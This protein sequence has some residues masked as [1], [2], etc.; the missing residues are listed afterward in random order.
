MTEKNKRE[1]KLSHGEKIFPAF[2]IEADGRGS[3]LSVLISGIIGVKEFSSEEV[4][5]ITRRESIKLTGKGL[6]ISVFEAKTVEISGDIET[7]SFVSKSY[8]RGK[9]K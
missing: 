7:I 5:V 3:Y 2:H 6:R 4:G 1:R 8:R 9:S